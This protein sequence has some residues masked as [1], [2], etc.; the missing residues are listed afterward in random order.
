MCIAIVLPSQEVIKEE[1]LIESWRRNPDGAGFAYAHKGKIVTAKGFM[2]Q[3][4]FLE[5]FARVR[6]K[7]TK[8][9]FLIHFRIRSTGAK[10]ADNTHPFVYE[11]G[12]MIHNGTLR[13][14][15]AKSDEG[16]SDTQ[17]FVERFGDRL[18]F[19]TVKLKNKELGEAV[20][21]NKLAFLFNN[22]EYSIVNES[23]GLWFEGVWYSN[24]GFKAYSS[25]PSTSTIAGPTCGVNRSI[26]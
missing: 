11:H 24:P 5:A 2:K 6:K 19:E 12:C 3:N 10:N 7:H 4:D 26:N 23:K 17:L 16:K 18:T 20:D 25:T 14:T 13:G 21:Y 15:G 9:N 22:G 8:K 1:F